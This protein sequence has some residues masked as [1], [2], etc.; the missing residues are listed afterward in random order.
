MC[1]AAAALPDAVVGSGCVRSPAR[2]YKLEQE[3]RGKVW[4]VKRVCTD[5]DTIL[6]ISR[7]HP[8]VSV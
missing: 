6:F 2:G 3:L 1:T 4:C 7:K 5:I 8:P